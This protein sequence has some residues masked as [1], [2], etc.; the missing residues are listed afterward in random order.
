MSPASS[1]RPCMH[2]RVMPHHQSDE[3]Q[4]SSSPFSSA[5][6]APDAKVT[7]LGYLHQSPIMTGWADEA[8][9]H[10]TK[11]A[12]W[13]GGARAQVDRA[14]YASCHCQ[15]APHTSPPAQLQ[16]IS[17]SSCTSGA[18]HGPIYRSEGRTKANG[19][20]RRLCFIS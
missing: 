19:D 9:L 12:G 3:Q 1:G 15:E 8:C 11:L 2:C 18:I 7:P 17:C 5:S 14:L 10:S 16:A 4:G 13:K 20:S 6:L